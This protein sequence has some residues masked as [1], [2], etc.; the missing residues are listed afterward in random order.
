[1]CGRY[2][3]I[4]SPQVRLLLHALGVQLYPVRYS[5]DIAPGSIISII[6]NP[7][8]GRRISDAIWWL[9]LDR[10]TLKPDYRYASFNSRSDKLSLPRSL[11][12]RPFQESR[13]II[14]ASAFIEGLGDKKTY[15]KIELRDSAIAFGGV[16]QHYLHQETGES[17]YAASIIT[18][19]PLPQWQHIHPKSMPLMLP[20]ADAALLD[21]WLDPEQRDTSNFVTLLEPAIR[22]AQQVTRI[23]RPSKWDALSEAFIIETDASGSE[24]QSLD[25]G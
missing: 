3:V 10:K 19:P 11:A 21:A 18:L 20:L 2:N 5:Q 23:G 1:M 9:M 24:Q 8:S 25:I 6:H 7:G 12:C 22:Q 13:C 17:V 15:H 14:P 4:D 16:C